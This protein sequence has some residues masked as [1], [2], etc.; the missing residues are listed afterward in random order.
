LQEVRKLFLVGGYSS[1]SAKQSLVESRR[2]E[3]RLEF[4]ALHDPHELS[5]EAM[6]KLGVCQLKDS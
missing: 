3:L 1:N 2:I 4:F 6:E 5:A